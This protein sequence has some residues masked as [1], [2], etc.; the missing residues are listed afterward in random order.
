MTDDPRK[1][2]AAEESIEDLEAPAAAQADVAGG[3]ICAEPTE[4]C[5]QPSCIDTARACIRLSLQKVLHEQ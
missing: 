1:E 2:E 5:A 3:E 4:F